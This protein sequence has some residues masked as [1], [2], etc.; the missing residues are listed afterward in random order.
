MLT[1]DL[2]AAVSPHSGYGYP[3]TPPQAHGFQTGYQNGY[4]TVPSELGSPY[5]AELSGNHQGEVAML[6]STPVGHHQTHSPTIPPSESTV[7]S[8]WPTD[9]K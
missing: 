3:N 5:V 9:K 8:G 4:Q 6:D 7:T 2:A 1:R